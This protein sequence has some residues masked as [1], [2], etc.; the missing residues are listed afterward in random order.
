MTRPMYITEAGW[1]G[2][3]KLFG[4]TGRLSDI[5]RDGVLKTTTG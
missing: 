1:F 3:R 5:L 2:W 4:G